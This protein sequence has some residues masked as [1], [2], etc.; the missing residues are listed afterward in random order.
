MIRKV[1]EGNLPSSSLSK[2]ILPRA[3]NPRPSESGGGRMSSCSRHPR[4]GS[5]SGSAPCSAAATRSRLLRRH[6]RGPRSDRRPLDRARPPR[7]ACDR[8]RRHRRS[9]RARQR[10]ARRPPNAVPDGCLADRIDHAGGVV[11]PIVA[12]A[13][14]LAAALFRKWRIAAFFVFVL[15]VESAT[16]RMTTLVVHS[17]RPHVHRLESLP[18]NASYPS[19]H[20]AASIAVYCGL[21]LLLTS[22]IKNRAVRVVAWLLAVLIAA[23]VALSR[24]YRGM[25][26]PLDVAGG[27]VIGIA[28]L[29]VLVLAC[30]SAGAAARDERRRHRARGQDARRRLPELRRVLEA[31][32]NLRSVLARGAEEQQGAGAGAARARRKGRARLRLGR[33]RHGAA[34]RRRP[35]RPEVHARDRPGR[36][37]ESPRNEP[38]ASRTTSKRR[39]RSDSTAT[40]AARRRPVQ[41]RALRGHGRAGFD[42]AMIRDAGRRPQGSPRPRRLRVER[43]EE[44]RVEAVRADDRGR[45]CGWFKGKATLHP[46]RQRRQARSAA[47]RSSRTRVPTTA[48]S[49]SASSPPRASPTGRGRS[50]AQ[51]SGSPATSPFVH[52]RPRR[53]SVKVKLDRERSATS[54]TAATGRR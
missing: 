23:F 50:P 30:R 24:M 11:L 54:S 51:S 47:S 15:A 6:V 5:R 3:S 33:R 25:H 35:R 2:R 20:T 27:I 26:H 10:L 45:R 4:E 38:R 14:A 46:A 21:A 31:R 39:S 16:Y 43:A 18:V 29:C 42:A 8:N 37:G 12:G 22:L 32:R 44:P 40:A 17:H 52:R 13:L 34:L 28:A 1:V 53:A 7:H 9:R 41:R 48:C 19:G 49:R 36:N